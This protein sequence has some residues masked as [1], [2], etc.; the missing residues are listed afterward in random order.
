MKTD[1]SIW[2][3]FPENK[4]ACSQ[5]DK[6]I[7]LSF[8]VWLAVPTLIINWTLYGQDSCVCLRWWPVKFEG[9]MWW[10]ACSVGHPLCRKAE[11]N[12]KVHA[13]WKRGQWSHQV[14]A[15]YLRQNN[16]PG[17]IS[18]NNFHFAAEIH[19]SYLSHWGLWKQKQHSY[20]HLILSF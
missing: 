8:W 20:S 15:T 12:T 14:T 4:K 3:A 11:Q 10:K 1:R 7:K 16:C 2:K 5:R 18:P 19:T 17:V 13:N 9:G 6:I